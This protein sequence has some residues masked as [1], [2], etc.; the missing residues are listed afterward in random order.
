MVCSGAATGGGTGG[1]CP[2]II[3]RPFFLNLH[4]NVFKQSLFVGG[5]VRRKYAANTMKSENKLHFFA[6]C[7]R[8]C[9]YTFGLI[10]RTATS[11]CE[12]TFNIKTRINPRAFLYIGYRT[13]VRHHT[14]VFASHFTLQEPNTISFYRFNLLITVLV[15]IQMSVA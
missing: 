5:G 11:K 3:F 10:Y 14:F 13:S 12:G 6:R 7:A 9:Q 1:A 8:G 2:P 15:S 4:E